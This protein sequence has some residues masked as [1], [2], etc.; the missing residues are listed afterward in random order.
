MWSVSKVTNLRPRRWFV[1]KKV[2]LDL[3]SLIVPICL[4]FHLQLAWPIVT[5]KLPLI[6]KKTFEEPEIQPY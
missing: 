2:V 6:K 3:G 5:T 4:K 1:E